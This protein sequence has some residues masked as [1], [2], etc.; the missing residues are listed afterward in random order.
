MLIAARHDHVAVAQDRRHHMRVDPGGQ[1]QRRR[2]VPRRVQRHRVDTGR[3][4]Q[5]PPSVQI[6]ARPNRAAIG[7]APHE[8][9]RI[10]PRPL[11]VLDEHQP[12]RLSQRN[13]PSPGASLRPGERQRAM[14]DLVLET[15]G[16]LPPPRR[17]PARP[18]AA[19]RPLAVVVGLAAAMHVLQ[20]LQLPREVDR[21]GVEVDP[22]PREAEQLGLPR[23]GQERRRP[24][25]RQVRPGGRLEVDR[26]ADDV[27]RLVDSQRLT[28][29]RRVPRLPHDRRDVAV[30]EAPALSFFQRLRQRLVRFLRRLRRPGRHGA[31][32]LLH[33]VEG[34]LVE[35]PVADVRLDVEPDALL[36]VPP[37]GGANVRA[38]NVEP[39]IEPR[40]ERHR[41]RRADA[42]LSNVVAELAQ[43]LGGHRFIAAVDH[44]SSPP[45][46]GCRNVYT[47]DPHAIGALEQTALAGRASLRCHARDCTHRCTQAG[48]PTKHYTALR[49][50]VTWCY[51]WSTRRGDEL[52]ISR[53]WRK[54]PQNRRSEAPCSSRCTQTCTQPPRP[55]RV[56]CRPAPN[57]QRIGASDEVPHRAFSR[58]RRNGSDRPVGVR[59]VYDGR[60]G[61]H[62]GRRS[63]RQRHGRASGQLGAR[64]QIRVHRRQRRARKVRH[65]PDRQPIH[66]RRRPRRVHRRDAHR[67]E[68]RR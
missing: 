12:Q 25:R 32:H 61:A 1:Q 37:G 46:I 49:A 11:R 43:L 3:R 21:P 26:R 28:L 15:G 48:T 67:Q 39:L 47:A 8:V 68:H 56:Q 59:A 50:D 53:S 64:R 62:R 44:S 54:S 22:V 52:L 60:I 24:P 17:A 6:V 38:V 9:V 33:V 16:Q 55:A 2:R 7:V 13:D 18:H 41:R 57:E 58:R 66:H 65:R 42:A 51:A 23:P 63:S 19:T 36:V 5:N 14:H 30:D 4:E 35:P 31:Q 20:L 45:T 40:A 10:R 27:P 34:E 29:A